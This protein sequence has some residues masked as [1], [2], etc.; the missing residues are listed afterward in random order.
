M[1]VDPPGRGSATI[2]RASGPKSGRSGS[3]CTSGAMT[4]RCASNSRTTPHHEWFVRSS[5]YASH[6]TLHAPPAT[7]STR[8]QL[9]RHQ[10]RQVVVTKE[11]L[12]HPRG[13]HAI[14]SDRRVDGPCSVTP[15]AAWAPV[16]SLITSPDRQAG[17]PESGVFPAG[18]PRRDAGAVSL[19]GE[20][21][22]RA[23]A[24]RSRARPTSATEMIPYGLAGPG[25]WI[26]LGKRP[27]G[28]P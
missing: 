16:L 7:G 13:C 9:T 27:S 22:Q 15:R 24:P 5:P 19:G 11:R 1:R 8:V 21:A 12:D 18:H 10:G 6:A 4:S 28:G 26:A 17:R 20:P 14:D 23:G 3:F 25:P 2:S